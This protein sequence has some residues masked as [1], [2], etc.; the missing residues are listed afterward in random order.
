MEE[1]WK[2]IPGYDGRYQASNLGNV[3]GKYKVLSPY[4]DSKGYKSLALFNGGNNKRTS[5]HRL[6]CAAFLGEPNGMHVNHKDKNPSNNCIDNLEYVTPKENLS[7]GSKRKVIGA[8]WDKR[9][10]TWVATI[11]LDGVSHY[12]GA[13]LT[14]KDAATAYLKVAKFLGV[15]NKYVEEKYNSAK[16][17][18]VKSKWGA[19]A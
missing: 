5:V 3:R 7:H 19:M 14:E 12:L 18:D 2:E 9:A 8:Y 15:C 4:T 16:F 1:V 6:V 10:E 13:Y 11:S 17:S